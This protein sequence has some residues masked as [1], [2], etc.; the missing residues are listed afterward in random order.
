MTAANQLKEQYP[1]LFTGNG[2]QSTNGTFGR[3]LTKGSAGTDV[4]SLQVFL[5]THGFPVAL[6]G[7]GSV[8]NETTLFSS[9]TQAALAKFQAAQGISPAVGYFGA[10]TRTAIES[11]SGTTTTPSAPVATQQS[12]TTTTSALYTRN[13]MLG[14]S[15]A[16]VKTLQAFLMGAQTG[17]KAALLKK[18]GVS[19]YF[20]QLTKDALIEFQLAKGIQPAQGN[21]GPATRATVSS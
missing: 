21:F 1:N 9:G 11:L 7:P 2:S 20:G 14:M 12:S 16:D 10:L 19:G 8:G 6:T 4:K 15:G 3:T 13:L 18:S 5:N 17:P